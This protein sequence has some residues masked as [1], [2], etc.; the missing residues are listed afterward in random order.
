LDANEIGPAT[1]GI[2]A[3]STIEQAQ[4]SITPSLAVGFAPRFGQRCGE[5]AAI[6][7]G[8]GERRGSAGC[9]PI[10]HSLRRLSKNFPQIEKFSYGAVILTLRSGIVALYRLHRDAVKTPVSKIPKTDVETKKP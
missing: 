2:S 1:A 4:V 7:S 3:V 9:Q 8:K 10:R 6:L 5:A